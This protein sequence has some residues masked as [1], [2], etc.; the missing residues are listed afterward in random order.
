M[1]SLGD[2]CLKTLEISLHDKLYLHLLSNAV[3]DEVIYDKI[4]IQISLVL[5]PMRDQIL[6][7]RK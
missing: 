4:Y 1:R 3:I 7:V 5:A 6:I 2:K